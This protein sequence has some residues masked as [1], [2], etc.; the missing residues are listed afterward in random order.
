[1]EGWPGSGTYVLEAK[2]AGHPFT[3]HEA[4]V[5]KLEPL[6]RA[7]AHPQASEWVKDELARVRRILSTP[8]RDVT[9]ADLVFAA[10]A[11]CR[12]GAGYCYPD[13]THDMHGH[14]FC[15]AC[16]L[17]TAP[18]GSEHDCAKPFAFWKIKGENQPSAGGATTRP[19]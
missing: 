4:L 19:K 8:D 15:S 9:A 12:C 7:A 3:L 6:E 10:T 5:A 17:G 1:M 18:A 14:W 2:D 13:F 16:L 11:R